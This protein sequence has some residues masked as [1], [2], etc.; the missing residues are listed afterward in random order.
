VLGLSGFILFFIAGLMFGVGASVLN[1][2]IVPWL[3]TH[4]LT[5][6]NGPLT[7]ALGLYFLLGAFILTAGGILFGLATIR[8]GIFSRWA[9]L[10]LII[11]VVV[12]LG[13]FLPIPYLGTASGVIIFAALYGTVTVTI[14]GSNQPRHATLDRHD[15]L[16]PNGFAW[17]VSLDPTSIL[18][19]AT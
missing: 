12:G 16:F 11:G 15:V 1:T 13:R 18:P 2:F 14:E 5:Q 4:G 3:A 19:L 17:C 8:A 6:S 7:P 10:L 9:G